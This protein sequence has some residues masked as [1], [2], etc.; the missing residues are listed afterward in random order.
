MAADIYRCEQKPQRS[1]QQTRDV[2]NILNHKVFKR[3][4]VMFFST[5]TTAQ[6]LVLQKFACFLPSNIFAACLPRDLFVTFVFFRHKNSET[7]RFF[8]PVNLASLVDCGIARLHLCRPGRH[9]LPVQLPQLQERLLSAASASGVASAAGVT[10][11]G[12][13]DFFLAP[14]APGSFAAAA[15]RFIL[16]ALYAAASASAASSSSSS[17]SIVGIACRLCGGCRRRGRRLC[18]R[19]FCRRRYCRRRCCWRRCSRRCCRSRCR[20]VVFFPILQHERPPPS[21]LCQG[22]IVGSIIFVLQYT[23][24]HPSHHEHRAF[25]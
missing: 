4:H 21:R 2:L 17:M 24:E 19:R 16:A 22:Q 25:H 5:A 18:R 8:I 7:C 11:S 13:F 3:C 10:P 1:T 15:G 20:S 23:L 6:S 14:A 12:S 9:R